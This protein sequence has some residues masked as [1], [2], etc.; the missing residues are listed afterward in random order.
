[1]YN[2]NMLKDL[3]WHIKRI[4][5]GPES[6]TYGSSLSDEILLV[7]NQGGLRRRIIKFSG[8][9][10]VNLQKAIKWIVVFSAGVILTLV[11]KYFWSIL[12]IGK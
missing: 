2:D 5:T 3:R 12:V 8:R 10:W 6:M 1:M 4:W 7:P 9:F 11:I